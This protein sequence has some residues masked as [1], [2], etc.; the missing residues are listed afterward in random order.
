MSSRVTLITGAS[1]GVGREIALGF[2]RAG[3]HVVLTAR[4]DDR[5]ASVAEEVAAENGVSSTHI[6]DITDH[7]VVRKVFDRVANDLGRI[8]ILCNNSGVN[9]AKCDVAD[10]SPDRF[11]AIHAVNLSGLYACSHSVLPQMIRQ[12]YG[13]IVNVSSRS[14]FTC[15]PGASALRKN[16]M[17]FGRQESD[18]RVLPGVTGIRL[19]TEAE[20]GTIIERVSLRVYPSVPQLLSDGAQ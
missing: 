19:R 11:A 8:D 5:L 7:E 14:A 9:F 12:S 10:V 13:R 1:R 18:S 15:N 4:D 2:A 20:L 17:F 6:L 3:A 16:A